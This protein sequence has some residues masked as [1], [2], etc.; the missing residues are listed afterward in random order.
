MY[1]LLLPNTDQI[2]GADVLEGVDKNLANTEDKVVHCLK[3]K[4]LH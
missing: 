1:N 2:E 3:A 4:R